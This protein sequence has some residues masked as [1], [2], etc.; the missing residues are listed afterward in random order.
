MDYHSLVSV[1]QVTIVAEMELW[2]LLM[3]NSVTTEIAL[4]MTAVQAR[5]NG[6][7]VTMSF[8]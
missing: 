4:A 8:R 2:I 5:V 3:E 7:V 6:S 1:L